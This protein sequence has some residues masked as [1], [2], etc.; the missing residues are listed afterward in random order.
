MMEQDYELNI[1]ESCADMGILGASN[2]FSI[3]EGS[4]ET[5]G[6]SACLYLERTTRASH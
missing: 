3:S 2:T 4:I 6:V 5:P 1:E